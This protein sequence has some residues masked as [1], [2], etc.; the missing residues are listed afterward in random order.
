VNTKGGLTIRHPASNR[1]FPTE[2]PDVEKM[3]RAP[4]ETMPNGSFTS[5]NVH[6]AI[7]DFGERQLF[8]RYLREGP[9]AIY[10]YWDVPASQ[11]QDLKLAGSKG[12][13]INAE[14]AY[15]YRYAL[16]GRDD[17]PDRHAIQSDFLRRFVYDP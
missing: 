3:E 17:F 6:S 15:E 5:S 12:S 11:W 2:G 1:R 10:Q 4:L 14:I 9:D 7:Y 8:V 16:F 13:L